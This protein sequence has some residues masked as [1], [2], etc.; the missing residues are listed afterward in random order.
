MDTLTEQ[1]I[2]IVNDTRHAVNNFQN[3][4]RSTAYTELWLHAKPGIVKLIQ[5]HETQLRLRN[6]S[7]KI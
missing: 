6:G 3:I 4:L 1:I 2:D 7:F 5:W